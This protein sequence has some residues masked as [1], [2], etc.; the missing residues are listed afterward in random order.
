MEAALRSSFK[1][2]HNEAKGRNYQQS[3]D[4]N[5]DC[6]L[7]P[8]IDSCEKLPSQELHPIKHLTEV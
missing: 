8:F 3:E 5:D 6:E 7:E 2:D 4:V 1:K